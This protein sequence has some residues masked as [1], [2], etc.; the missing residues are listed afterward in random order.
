M[1]S[2]A[3]DEVRDNGTPIHKAAKMFRVPDSTLRD[4]FCGPMHP[5]PESKRFNVNPGPASTLT[6]EEEQ[7]LVNHCSY[8][9]RIGYRYSRTEF[10]TLATEYAISLER[11]KSTDPPFAQSWYERFIK[12]HPDILLA[13]AKRLSIIRAKSTSKTELCKYFDSLQSII[14]TYQ[15]KNKPENI[16]NID[17]TCLTMEHLPSNVICENGASSKTITANRGQNVTIVAAGSAVGSRIPPYYVFT[18]KSWNDNLL[19]GSTPGSAGTVTETGLPNSAVFSDFLEHHFLKHAPS[20]GSKIL[21]LFDGHKSQINLTLKEWG[22]QHNIVFFVI[23]PQTSHVTQTVD[24]GCFGQLKRTYYAEIQA[25]MT[26]SSGMKINRNN[27]AL[28]SSKAYNK[29]VTPDNL[30]T[31]FRKTGIF[32]LE[33]KLITSV[34]AAPEQKSKEKETA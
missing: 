14:D 3:Y 32:P 16:W 34:E 17:E 10:M 7:Q 6:Y 21:L 28:V 24:V 18:G 8:M 15:L 27:I 5:I 23:P 29:A 25:F 9:A 22:E 19:D 1:L 2:Q 33:K 26:Q 20:N 12:R 11:K 31:S 13:I 4:R 30:I